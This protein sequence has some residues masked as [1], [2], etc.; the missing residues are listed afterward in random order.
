M[1]KVQKERK[2]KNIQTEL[3]EQQGK[4]KMKNYMNN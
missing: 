3:N 1:I 2:R 4:E